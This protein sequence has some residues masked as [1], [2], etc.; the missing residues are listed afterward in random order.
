MSSISPR[1]PVTNA[2]L[3]NHTQAYK[4][5][6]IK[7]DTMMALARKLLEEDKPFHHLLRQCKTH[8]YLSVLVGQTTLSMDI[9]LDDLDDPKSTD[10]V[11]EASYRKRSV[12]L[13]VDRGL[14]FETV[15]DVTIQRL[16]KRIPAT[17]SIRHLR[18]SE[19]AVCDTLTHMLE[20]NTQPLNSPT[21]DETMSLNLLSPD[22]DL[23]SDSP[24]RDV[25][26]D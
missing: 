20:G 17:Y 11:S 21:E 13:K 3:T 16:R 6:D 4:P 22:I 2:W 14:H 23:E 12:F 8:W 5:R 26:S 19:I 9:Y 18:S 1:F 24:Y 10:L 15:D 25:F 7:P